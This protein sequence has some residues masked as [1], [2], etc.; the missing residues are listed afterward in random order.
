MIDCKKRKWAG[1]QQDI[2]A[3]LLRGS[4][5]KRKRAETEIII[6]EKMGGFNCVIL[7]QYE[8]LMVT[9]PIKYKNCYFVASYSMKMHHY[10]FQFFSVFIFYF[11]VFSSV[12]F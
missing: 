4:T 3:A 2:R 1:S 6:L 5:G 11:S 12:F 9:M 7:L 10:A 8:I